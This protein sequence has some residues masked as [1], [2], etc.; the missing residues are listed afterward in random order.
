M[1]K[2]TFNP[3]TLAITVALLLI[4]LVITWQVKD[5][6]TKTDIRGR[7]AA[8]NTCNGPITVRVSLDGKT[9]QLAITDTLP[10]RYYLHVTAND[11][12]CATNFD[13]YSNYCDLKNIC[14]GWHERKPWFTY[15]SDA[16]GIA[17]IDYNDF[18]KTPMKPGVYK[19]KYRPTGSNIPYGN[20]VTVN[21]PAYNQ[22][23]L[24]KLSTGTPDGLNAVSDISQYFNGK[25]GYTFLYTT[26]NYITNKTGNTRLQI[27]EEINTCGYRL[28]PWR[29]TKDAIDAYHYP[30]RFKTPWSPTLAPDRDQVI[31]F[32]LTSPTYSFP[33]PL[34][35]YNDYFVAIGDKR[36]GR[37]TIQ[38]VRE[39]NLIRTT[40]YGSTSDQFPAYNFGVKTN[41]PVPYYFR[42]N[43]SRYFSLYNKTDP[44]TSQ[45]SCPTSI[46]GPQSI[47]F[48][49]SQT[50]TGWRVRMEFENINIS[51]KRFLYNG[52]SLRF[53]VYEGGVDMDTG[54]LLRETWYM[55]KGVGVVRIQQKNFNYASLNYN[56]GTEPGITQNC[57]DDPDC[58]ADDITHPFIDTV[59]D[60][61]FLNPQLNITVSADGTNYS[62]SVT[63]TSAR[64]YYLKATNTPY[65]GYLEVLAAT[66]PK[67]W[68]WMQD[69]VVFVS[70]QSLTSIAAGVYTRQFRIWVP[71][72]QF[73][74]ETR[75]SDT[76][77][78]WSNQVSVTLTK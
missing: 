21:I 46:P 3:F 23:S 32:F 38:D 12:P 9:P 53:D 17:R 69:G 59:L 2:K 1:K 52:P 11:K 72:D 22:N 13:V 43:N 27:E 34:T 51:G 20:E 65:T 45:S 35:A 57:A 56:W 19:A 33:A 61:Y 6:A 7:A 64:G 66:G 26:H 71:D 76:A 44:S 31:R 16:N 55:V 37:S 67:K 54:G 50:K 68:Y 77:I 70:P 5:K 60:E 18:V 49:D 48:S 63:T 40:F 14:T 58:R 74:A 73:T 10:V 8:A 15:R 47:Y 4:G 39:Q 25:P 78:P 42:G 24:M 75:V 62:N 36:Y 41:M 30:W 28:M 29:F